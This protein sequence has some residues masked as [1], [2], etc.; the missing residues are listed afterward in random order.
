MTAVRARPRPKH[1][2]QRTCV[3][4]GSATAKREL[5]RLVR[6]P[7]G[8]V[9]PDPTGKRPGRGAYLCHN[10]ECWER[11]IKKGRLESALRTNLSADDREALLRYGAER[12][13]AE[14]S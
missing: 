11:A 10:P 7:T 13:A 3:G 9:E 5:I 6:I 12:L 1:A 8:A 14:V 4:C 2:P